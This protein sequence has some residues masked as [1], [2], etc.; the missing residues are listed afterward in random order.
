MGTLLGPRPPGTTSGDTRAPLVVPKCHP[1]PTSHVWFVSHPSQA[2]AVLGASSRAA[3]CPLAHSL[4]PQGVHFPAGWQLPHPPAQAEQRARGLTRAETRAGGA[5]G[6]TSTPM[7]VLGSSLRWG[8][9]R[10][11]HSWP[12]HQPL[13][14]E[15]PP[16]IGQASLPQRESGSLS[17]LSGFRQGVPLAPKG[18]TPGPGVWSGYTSRG[19]EAL[20]QIPTPSIP[21]LCSTSQLCEAGKNVNKV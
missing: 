7:L 11:P 6:P 10:V 3:S 17:A 13:S 5:D 18:W 20:V 15:A 4:R 9:P 19:Q 14:R 1:G 12:W 2:G 16:G 21:T 8:V